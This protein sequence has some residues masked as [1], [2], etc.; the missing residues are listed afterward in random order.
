[1]WLVDLFGFTGH[2]VHQEIL[3]EGVG[4]GEV[5]FA[6]AHFGD[7]LDEVDK[8][9]VAGEHEGVDHDAGALALVYFFEGLADDEGIESKGIFV[10]AAVLESEGGGLA[11][12]DHDDLAH[13]FFLAKEDALGEAKA[14]AGV[15]VIW[16]DLDAG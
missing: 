2:V 10:D 15:G 4:S 1:V 5:G 6:A 16:A 3:A 11:V 13:I 14:L 9:I 12:S 8:R 7:F